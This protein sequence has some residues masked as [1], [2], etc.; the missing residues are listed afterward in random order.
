MKARISRWVRS[1]RFGVWGGIAELLG[2]CF[3]VTIFLCIC[4]DY[5]SDASDISP[6]TGRWLFSVEGALPARLHQSAAVAR[7]DHRM[8]TRVC[9]AV[10]MSRV[11]VY[12][13]CRC[14]VYYSVNG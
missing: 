2:N 14:L 9:V 1:S 5:S 7:I 13:G 11:P 4:R 12:N 3:Y 8:W 10:S 6:P